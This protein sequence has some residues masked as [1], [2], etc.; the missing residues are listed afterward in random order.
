[1]I[2]FTIFYKNPLS[3]DF[4]WTPRYSWDV[5]VSAYNSSERVNRVFENVQATSKHWLVCPEYD[6]SDDEMPSGNYFRAD[7][8][9]EAGFIRQFAKVTPIEWTKMTVCVD[10]TG[11]I[12]PYLLFLLRWLVEKG[13]D[14]F[15]A[16]Y[17]EPVHYS[18]K[19][20]TQFSSGG[21]KDVRQV[22]GFEGIHSRDGSNNVLIIG[23]GYDS[24]LIASVAEA[25]DNAKKVQVLGLPSLRADM[26][27]ENLL[28]V[29]LAQDYL[30]NDERFF[31]PAHDP[32]V[33][34]QVINEIVDRLNAQ[35]RITN[36]YLSPLATKAQVLGF[37]LYY[38][39]LCG[40]KPASIIFP[41]ST[42]YGKETS[43]GISRIWKYTVDLAA[44][45]KAAAKSS[46]ISGGWGS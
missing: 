3:P 36:L 20:T 17:S 29:E 27:Q 8:S 39:A 30:G 38:L 16:I 44:I 4:S 40:K 11:F 37:G 43:K 6:Y 14:R 12:R 34:A 41:V 7:G 28:R 22:A 31:A 33:T 15:D 23:S 5:F 26:F 19:E 21:V 2:D 46:R 18:E 45:R 25:K 1:M 32:F 10:T 9:N 35:R 13:V 24:M 42:R